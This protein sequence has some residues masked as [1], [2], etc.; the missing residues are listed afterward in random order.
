MGIH[1][2]WK[3]FL[4]QYYT[5]V[6]RFK[7]TIRR[8]GKDESARNGGQT[9]GGKGVFVYCGKGVMAK[10]RATRSDLR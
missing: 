10:V 8:L 5:N 7:R 6:W 3:L 9:I 2:I 1:G 4:I